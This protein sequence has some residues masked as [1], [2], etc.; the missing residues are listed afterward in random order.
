MAVHQEERPDISSPGVIV[1]LVASAVFWV[2]TGIILL[3]LFD[4]I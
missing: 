4:R 3:I 1:A 2:A